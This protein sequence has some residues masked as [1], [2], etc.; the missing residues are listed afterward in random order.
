ME[1][2]VEEKVLAQRVEVHVYLPAYMQQWPAGPGVDRWRGGQ[3]GMAWHV[4][5]I[6]R[7]GEGRAAQTVQ[8]RIWIGS[9]D[10]TKPSPRCQPT[11]HPSVRPPVYFSVPQGHRAAAQER[12]CHHEHGGPVRVARLA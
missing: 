8:P 5:S 10:R 7:G 11:T 9:A 4:D 1:V 12:G 6:H 3:F 2:E